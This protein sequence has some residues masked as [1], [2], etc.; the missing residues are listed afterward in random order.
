MTAAAAAF[1]VTAKALKPEPCTLPLQVKA[2]LPDK[3]LCL[4]ERCL[5]YTEALAVLSPAWSFPGLCIYSH[6]ML[7]GP[8]LQAL[9][10]Q[11]AA[12]YARAA[13]NVSSPRSV[14]GR[15]AGSREFRGFG[16]LGREGMQFGCM[17][18]GRGIH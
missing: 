4:H 6:G 14:A 1:L 3:R 18:S 16:S 8:V 5:P 10:P 12:A 15:E 11:A 13:A 7:V 17:R 2:L 9:G